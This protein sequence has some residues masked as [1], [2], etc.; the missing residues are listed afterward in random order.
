M[1]G[2]TLT[3]FSHKSPVVQMRRK[4]TPLGF[5]EKKLSKNFYAI[6]LEVI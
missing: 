5:L 4:Q 1:K 6:H 3:R 2:V